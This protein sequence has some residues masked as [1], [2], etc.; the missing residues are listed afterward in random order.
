VSHPSQGKFTR[1]GVGIV[2]G[3]RILVGCAAPTPQFVLDEEGTRRFFPLN[4]A[5]QGQSAGPI[6]GRS[7]RPALGL[8]PK[9]TTPFSVS[10]L[11]HPRAG[12]GNGPSAGASWSRLGADAGVWSGT[13]LI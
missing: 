11:S 12:K 1:V 9:K 6:E 2:I 5:G 3:T 8:R 10:A 4:R 7:F 13:A